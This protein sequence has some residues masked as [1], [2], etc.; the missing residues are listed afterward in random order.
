MKKK[1]KILFMLLLLTHVNHVFA[2]SFTMAADFFTSAASNIAKSMPLTGDRGFL[3]AAANSVASTTVSGFLQPMIKKKFFDP[4]IYIHKG[5]GGFSTKIPKGVYYNVHL[6]IEIDRYIEIL[7]ELEPC[8]IKPHFVFRGPPGTGKTMLAKIIANRTGFSYEFISGAAILQFSEAEAI[9]EMSE[10]FD[11]IDR[12]ARKRS[13]VT[14]VIFDEAQD[15]LMENFRQQRFIMANINNFM[16]TRSSEPSSNYFFIFTYNSLFPIDERWIRRIDHHIHFDL[17]DMDTRNKLWSF[18]LKKEV[19]KI[20][21]R[22]GSND[23]MEFFMENLDMV[24]AELSAESDGF[25]GSNIS[26]VCKSISRRLMTRK[27]W[28]SFSIETSLAEIANT[29][30]KYQI[31]GIDFGVATE[32]I[33]KA[34]SEADDV[35]SGE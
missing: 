20:I 27:P 22:R 31:P 6:Q 1:S 5:T 18:Y 30:K 32:R 33:R 23:E 16:F 2:L 34:K 8:D 7:R 10:L 15:F 11:R 24:S 19:R 26:Q 9:R 13:D 35:P 12:R 21:K 3:N 17:P 25:S 28:R 29:R 4:K 14:V